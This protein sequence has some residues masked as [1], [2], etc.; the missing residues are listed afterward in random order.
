M[1]KCLVIEQEDEP[2]NVLIIGK[3][4]L[5]KLAVIQTDLVAH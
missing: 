5:W 4:S 2:T 3:L 1:S